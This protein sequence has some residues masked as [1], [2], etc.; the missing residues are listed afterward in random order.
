MASETRTALERFEGVHAENIARVLETAISVQRRY[1]YFIWLHNSLQTFLP[2]QLIVCGAYKRGRKQLQLEAFNSIPIPDTALAVV[3]NGQSALMQRAVG[4]WID[5]L[6]KP[7]ALDLAAQTGR[8]LEES[9]DLLAN[10]GFDELLIHGISRPQRIA[11]VES[12]FVFATPGKRSTERQRLYLDLLIPHLHSTYLRVQSVEL[13]MNDSAALAPREGVVRPT[14]TERERQIL[15]W[16]REGMSNHQI[17]T[18]LNISPLTVKNHVQKILR[19]LGAT[20]RAQAVAR[21]MTLNLL[22]RSMNEG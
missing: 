12:L 14:I 16:V 18:E 17:G 19:K 8:G 15:G 2:H 3:T 13:E 22:G 20:N 4:A 1:Q 5:N 6:G 11:E 21:A 9:R 7:L 10:A